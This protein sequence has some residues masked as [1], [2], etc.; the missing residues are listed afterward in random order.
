MGKRLVIVGSAAA[1]VAAGAMLRGPMVHVSADPSTRATSDRCATYDPN[2]PSPDHFVDTIDNAYFPLPV[3]RTLLYRGS[4]DGEPQTERV[5]VTSDTRVIEG[6]TAT[7]VRDVA[8]HGGQA[9]ERTTDWYAQ[10]DQGNVWYL[11]EATRS[12]E[13]GTVDRSGSWIA[14]QDGGKPGLIMEADPRVPDAY[15]QECL[16]GEAE[17]M[18]WVVSVGGSQRVPYGT[19]HRVLRTLEYA[20][21]EPNVLD[22]KL[23]APGLGIVSERALA[24]DHEMWTLVGVRG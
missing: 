1:V 23:Y 10:D 9:L 6:I 19:V 7:R 5:T 8:R 18:A 11:G 21:I 12:Y 16:Q 3:G 17:D 4:K 24:G 20:P 14:G 13:G 2:L 15:R 22:Q